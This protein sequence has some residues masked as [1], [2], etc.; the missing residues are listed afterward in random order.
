MVDKSNPIFRE[1]IWT[2]YQKRCFYNREF[3]YEP[4]DLLA[5]EIKEIWRF[6]HFISQELPE[7]VLPE[8]QLVQTVLNLKQ[9]IDRLKLSHPEE[10]KE[11]G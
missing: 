1:A 10:E 11:A 5:G 2:V 8:N 6:V 4:Y 7:P 9:D 3:I